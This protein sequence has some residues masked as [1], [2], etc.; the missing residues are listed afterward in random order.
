MTVEAEACPPHAHG[1]MTLEGAGTPLGARA[2]AG[3]PAWPRLAIPRPKR[4]APS[5]ARAAG[6]LVDRKDRRLP[7]LYAAPSLR[8]AS[9]E[10]PAQTQGAVERLCRSSSRPVLFGLPG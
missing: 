7:Q 8:R 6:E 4:S 2:P 10:S 5:A 1:P 3:R 9:R